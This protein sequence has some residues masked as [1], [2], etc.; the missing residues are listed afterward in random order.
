MVT[1]WNVAIVQI[2]VVGDETPVVLNPDVEEPVALDVHVFVALDVH[3]FVE[4][5]DAAT[6]RWSV[7]QKDLIFYDETCRVWLAV[8]IHL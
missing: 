2:V 1:S 3:V 5:S 4:L 7:L 8:E 6:S